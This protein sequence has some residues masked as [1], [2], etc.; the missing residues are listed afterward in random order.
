M[1]ASCKAEKGEFNHFEENVETF[2]LELFV[3]TLETS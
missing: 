2:L 1:N 3:L